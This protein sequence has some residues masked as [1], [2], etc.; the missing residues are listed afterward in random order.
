MKTRFVYYSSM[1]VLILGLAVS[2]RAD[3]QAHGGD[4]L[5]NP[6]PVDCASEC[7]LSAYQAYWLGCRCG[8]N[9]WDP[10]SCKECQEENSATCLDIEWNGAGGCHYQNG[11]CFGWGTCIYTG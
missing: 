7:N 8:S 9:V 5:E 3:A 2:F 1:F 6:T 11:M 10:V 4:P